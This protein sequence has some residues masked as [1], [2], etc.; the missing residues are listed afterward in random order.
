MLVVNIAY[1]FARLSPHPLCWFSLVD[2]LLCFLKRQDRQLRSCYYHLALVYV[3]F[4]FVK[5]HCGFHVHHAGT[6]KFY[7]VFVYLDFRVLFVAVCLAD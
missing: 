7:P 1:E 4:A 6:D 5:L 3:E 2:C